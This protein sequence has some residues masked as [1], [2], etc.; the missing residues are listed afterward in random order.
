MRT[1]LLVDLGLR[2]EIQASN[3]Q[4]ADDIQDPTSIQYTRV[5]KGNLLGH[6]HHPKDDDD[7]STIASSLLVSSCLVE[8]TR[9]LCVACDKGTYTWGLRPAIVMIVVEKLRE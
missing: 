1:F 9:C 5:I 2:V 4:V 6:L 8:H 7:V 3:D